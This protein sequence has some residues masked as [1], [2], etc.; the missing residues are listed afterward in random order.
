MAR[1]RHSLPAST[2]V[3]RNIITADAHAALFRRLSLSR[4]SSSLYNYYYLLANAYELRYKSVDV[5]CA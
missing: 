1:W 3:P 2:N 5:S 4:T